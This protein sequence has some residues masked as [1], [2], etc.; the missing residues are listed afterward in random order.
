MLIGTDT[1]AAGRIT[2]NR[3]SAIVFS[4]ALQHW[5]TA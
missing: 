3:I 5:P 1:L 4:S 2:R